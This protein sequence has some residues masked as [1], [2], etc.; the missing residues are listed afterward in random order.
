MSQVWQGR[1]GGDKAGGWGVGAGGE[2]LRGEAWK[3][4]I[5]SQVWHILFSG[6][7]MSQVWSRFSGAW[8]AAWGAQ[9]EGCV[10]AVQWGTEGA[11]VEKG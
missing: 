10:C 1:G 3:V 5:M 2:G 7:Q 8:G 6:Q 4:G 11:A 9:G